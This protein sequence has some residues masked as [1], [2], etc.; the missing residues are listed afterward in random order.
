MDRCHPLKESLLVP[1]N[2]A[3]IMLIHEHRTQ[4]CSISIFNNTA[5]PKPILRTAN[6]PPCLAKEDQEVAELLRAQLSPL[7]DQPHLPSNRL[8]LRPLQLIHHSNKLPLPRRSRALALQVSSVRWLALQQ[9]LLSDPQSATQ[10][11]GFLVEDQASQPN[12]R[13]ITVPWLLKTN[14]QVRITGVR[15]AATWMHS[16][17]QSA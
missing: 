17:S 12:N 13:Q 2:G 4:T 3:S 15:E 6:K 14:R 5:H 8:A 11:E 16:S 10:S 7:K 1:R 9:V